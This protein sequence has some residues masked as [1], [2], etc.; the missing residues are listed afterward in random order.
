MQQAH[1]WP[2]NRRVD[3][4]VLEIDQRA[5]ERGAQSIKR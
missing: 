2:A 3:V 4:I 5:G 1:C